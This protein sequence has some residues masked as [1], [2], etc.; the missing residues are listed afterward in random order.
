MGQATRESI[1]ASSEQPARRTV[2]TQRRV[3]VSAV[4]TTWLLAA[5][6]WACAGSRGADSIRRHTYPPEFQYLD[7]QTV[8]TAML[9]LTRAVQ[10]LTDTLARRPGGSSSKTTAAESPPDVQADVVQLLESMRQSMARLGGTPSNHPVIAAHRETFI[11]DI[12]RAIAAARA[13]P[14]NYFFAGSVAGSCR[15]CHAPSE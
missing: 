13:E 7:P 5:G 10:Q 8:D 11:A 3:V 14:P 1:P 6:F 9:K 2:R 4:A 15:H 12:E